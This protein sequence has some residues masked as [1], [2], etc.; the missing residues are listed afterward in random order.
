MHNIAL[1]TIG[2]IACS[3]LRGYVIQRGHVSYYI[4]LERSAV[5]HGFSPTFHAYG[6]GNEDEDTSTTE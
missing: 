5:L 1:R 2:I 4:P 3:S 6:I